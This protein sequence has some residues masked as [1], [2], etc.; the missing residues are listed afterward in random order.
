MLPDAPDLV[1]RAVWRSMLECGGGHSSERL[2]SILFARAFE[3][4]L[5]SH[6]WLKK[7]AT[8]VREDLAATYSRD[9]Q[10]WLLVAPIIGVA[11]GLVITLLNLL[12]L[13][14]V[15]ARLLPAYMAH[16]WMILPGLLVGFAITG[17]IMQFRTPDQ[18]SFH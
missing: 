5:F 2:L 3:S 14:A 8:L 7:Y 13:D 18:S 9:V 6:P 4:R 16:H 11:T 15:W 1:Q 10:K 17:L 12:I